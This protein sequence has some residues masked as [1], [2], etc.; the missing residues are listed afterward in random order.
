[1]A[2]IPDSKPPRSSASGKGP[3]QSGNTYITVSATPIA[4]AP[5][6]QSGRRKPIDPNDRCSARVTT[7]ITTPAI[8][9]NR[10]C[11]PTWFP[12]V[13]HSPN[14]RRE[15]RASAGGPARARSNGATVVHPQENVGGV[16]DRGVQSGN[17]TAGG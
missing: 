10:S 14:A 8:E 1:M 16:A 12:N 13:G 6:A 15:A 9:H 4:D 11:R 3:V 17:C 5:D 2:R 7:S